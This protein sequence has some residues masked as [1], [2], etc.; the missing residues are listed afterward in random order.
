MRV[1]QHVR[2]VDIVLVGRR[3]PDNENLGLG[4]LMAAAKEAGLRARIAVLNSWPDLERVSA[5]IVDL[6]PL[7]VGLAMPDGGSAPLPLSLGQL[8]AAKG[9]QGHI[10][11]GGPFATLARQWLLDRYDWLDSVVRYAGE[12]PLTQLA[13][14]LRDGTEAPPS[15]P[16]LTTRSGDGVA[17]DV[18]DRTGLELFPLHDEFPRLLG[19]PMV[20]ITATRGCP[21]RCLY[22]GP[23][24]LQS[25]E[26]AEGQRAGHQRQQLNRSGVG[27][28]RRRQLGSVCD[29]MAELWH[30]HGVRYFYFVDEHLLPRQPAA[31]LEFLREWKT[32]LQRRDV[33][34]LGIGCM[35]RADL[36]TDEVVAAFVDLGLVRT[37]VGIELATATEKR[38]LG[39][40]GDIRRAV[41]AMKSLEVAGVATSCN[42]MLV[43]PYSTVDTIEAGLE[44][45]RRLGASPF[46]ATQMQVYHGTKLHDRIAAQGRLQ[47]NP[48]Q[49]E[50][51]FADPVITRFA[52]LFNRL[53][54]E[55]FGDYSLTCQLHDAALAVALAQR[56][57]PNLVFDDLH[58]RCQEI[59][60]ASNRCRVVAYRRALHLARTNEPVAQ[61]EAVIEQARR[62]SEAIVRDIEG[63]TRS[64]CRRAARPYHCFAPMRYAA[65]ARLVSFCLSGASAAACQTTATT[66]RSGADPVD[67]PRPLDAVAT[68][69]ADSPTPPLASA[70]SRSAPA[71]THPDAGD[72]VFCTLAKRTELR[73]IVAHQA[74]RIDPCAD[75]Q[76]AFGWG[77]HESAGPVVVNSNSTTPR[78]KGNDNR[79]RAALKKKLNEQQL[80]CLTEHSTAIQLPGERSHQER[81]VIDKVHETCKTSWGSHGWHSIVVE[82][83]PHG[84][85]VSIRNHGT[86]QPLGVQTLACIK[87]ALK[88]LTFPCLAGARITRYQPVIM[89]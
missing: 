2:S 29:E 13:R 50:Y 59:S 76:V 8:L 67:G 87:K 75:R 82:M 54:F 38:I 47:G 84:R 10:T 45:L 32:Q 51:L 60:A 77:W 31:A 73:R 70:P 35:L 48:L 39:R 14:E 26:R 79:I 62:A 56:L 49:Y 36:L 30:G 63:V 22:C 3:L 12:V 43:H 21:G 19:H 33:G 46:E 24:A 44:F 64:V 86:V 25:Q 71:A 89:E 69:A 7:V 78:N 80:G 85:P 74:R 66:T 41:G 83:G 40:G 15:V 81:E 57:Y 58:H 5:Q 52:A 27:G 4:Y 53:R 16:G 72:P 65:A 6:E 11:A 1:D 42:L 88:G 34:S 23:A 68:T 9:Y 20:Q 55:A 37:F 18:L 61:W 17:A 28:V